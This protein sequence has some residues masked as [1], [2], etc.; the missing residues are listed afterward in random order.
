MAITYMIYCMVQY[1]NEYAVFNA[2]KKGSSSD[3]DKELIP[4]QAIIN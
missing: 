3:L 4:H 1:W 2:I